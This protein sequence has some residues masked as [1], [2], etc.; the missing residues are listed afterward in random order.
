MDCQSEAN[1][2]FEKLSMWREE[3]HKQVSNIIDT[4]K[5]IINQ[6][7]CDLVNEVSSLQIKLSDMSSERKVLLET[8]DSLNGEIR[9]QNAKLQSF[10]APKENINHDRQEAENS[11]H[12]M[13]EA[14]HQDLGNPRI[15]CEDVDNGNVS[16]QEIQVTNEALSASDSTFDRL[17]NEDADS[18]EKIQA[19]RQIED[20]ID[21]KQEVEIGEVNQSEVS[22]S[23]SM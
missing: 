11:D 6:G 23:H 22:S 15:N 4:H 13:T 16:T 3:S 8:V 18:P 19:V 9:Q 12:E 7:I 10:L 1:Y 20:K 21:S 17:A 2:L 5:S 14:T